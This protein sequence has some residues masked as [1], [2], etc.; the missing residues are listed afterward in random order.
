MSDR[1]NVFR[2]VVATTIVFLSAA[3]A[4]AKAPALLEPV[5]DAL[6]TNGLARIGPLRLTHRGTVECLSFSPDGK[7]LASA[8][9]DGV[10]HIWDVS[11]G[12]EKRRFDDGA[13]DIRQ[14]VWSPN[15]KIL[16]LTGKSLDIDLFDAETFA[17][18]QT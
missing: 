16:A 4:S 12:R 11:T 13:R 2:M 9:Q 14:I 3:W 17:P 15:G 7:W 18:V 8:A 5:D 1:K 6:P 10:L